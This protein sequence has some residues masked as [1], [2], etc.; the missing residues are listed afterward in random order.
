MT[1][2]VCFSHGRELRVYPYYYAHG[3]RVYPLAIGVIF[4]VLW[5]WMWIVIVLELF[6]FALSSD[7]DLGVLE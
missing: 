6:G 4:W 1:L 3:L 5:H 2:L 7:K